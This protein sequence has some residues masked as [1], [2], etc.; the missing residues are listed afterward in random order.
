MFVVNVHFLTKR[1]PKAFEQSK[2]FVEICIAH[3]T[4]RIILKAKCFGHEF[5]SL[6][7]SLE[8]SVV[9]L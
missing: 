2:V 6:F 9:T 3:G 5:L 1:Q 4:T 7:L 8:A